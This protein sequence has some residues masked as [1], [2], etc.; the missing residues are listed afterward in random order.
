MHYKFDKTRFDSFK[1]ITQ[2]LT[3]A[4]HRVITIAQLFSLKTGTK[5]EDYRK[6]INI[7]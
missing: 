7:K 5:K 3:T 6:D 2:R 1:Q 4:D